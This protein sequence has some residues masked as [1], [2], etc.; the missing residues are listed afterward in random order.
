MPSDE[1]T[2]ICHPWELLSDLKYLLFLMASSV[3]FSSLS[4]ICQ[5]IVENAVHDVKTLIAFVTK[6]DILCG[7]WYVTNIDVL[8]C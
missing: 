7:L 2:E 6:C 3:P 1:P 5:F 4:A 8:F